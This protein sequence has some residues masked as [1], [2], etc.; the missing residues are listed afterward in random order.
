VSGASTPWST[1]LLLL[2]CAALA[3]IVA[4]ELS[5]GVPLAPQVTAA[6]PAVDL[7]PEPELG[8]FEPPPPQRFDEISARPLFAPSRRPY[9]P[10]ALPEAPVPLPVEVAPTPLQLIGVILTE[11]DRSALIQ[12]LGGRRAIWVREGERLEG[13]MIEEI[14]RDRVLLRRDDLMETIALRP[15][16]QAS[17]LGQPR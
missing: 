17:Q 16:D 13:W 3:T 6:A 10:P 5:G 12:P 4:V 11:Q 9:E 1:G 8:T 14:G 7:G 2:V 15:D